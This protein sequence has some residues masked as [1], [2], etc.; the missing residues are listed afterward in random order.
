MLSRFNGR[1]R[2][3]LLFLQRVH[4]E[5]SS[6]RIPGLPC[7]NRQ[8]SDLKFP[9]TNPHQR[10]VLTYLGSNIVV[11][12]P[13]SIGFRQADILPKVDYFSKKSEKSA[14]SQ[15]LSSFVTY[16]AQVVPRTTSSGSTR[17]FCADRFGYTSISVSN[18]SNA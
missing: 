15:K 4:S 2:H 5:A 13:Q 16:T 14:K 10:E 8:L 18:A 12:L 9:L 1:T 11:N 6:A 3:H 7:T 17:I